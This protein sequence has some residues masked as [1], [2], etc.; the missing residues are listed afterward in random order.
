MSK[1]HSGGPAPVPP[2]NRPQSGPPS[3]A[4]GDADAALPDDAHNGDPF[5]D[6]DA[7]RRLG[8]FESAGEHARQQPSK[9]NDGETHSQ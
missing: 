4:P 8:G 5:N 2:G 9:L 7:Q 6:Q 1:K 3:G